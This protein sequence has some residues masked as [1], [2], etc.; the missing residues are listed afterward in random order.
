MIGVRPFTAGRDRPGRAT[1]TICW[2]MALIFIILGVALWYSGVRLF[3][4]LPNKIQTVLAE[5][6]PLSFRRS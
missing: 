3:S 1:Q 4:V 6:R 2:I 5:C